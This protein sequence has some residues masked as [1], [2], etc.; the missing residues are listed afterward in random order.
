M[1]Q[2]KKECEY[3]MQKL[4]RLANIVINVGESCEEYGLNE[5]DLPAGIQTILVSLKRFVHSTAV[6]PSECCSLTG[7]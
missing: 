4:T 3:V 1:K 6:F 2:C 5:S 7:D